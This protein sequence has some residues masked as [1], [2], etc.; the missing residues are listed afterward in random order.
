M[1]SRYDNRITAINGLAQYKPLFKD[2]GVQFIR[3][4]KS[5]S[6]H[7]PTDIQMAKVR[8]IDHIWGMGDRYYKLASQYYDDPTLWWVIAWYNQMPTESHVK[9]G[10]VVVIPLPY[11]VIIPIL[12]QVE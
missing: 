12:M 11:D 4:F 3:Q 1:V 8:E 10:D 9:M 2:R 5:P 7:F 6:M